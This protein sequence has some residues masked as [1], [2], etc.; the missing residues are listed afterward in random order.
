[1]TKKKENPQLAGRKTLYKPEYCKQMLDFFNIS[2]TRIEYKTFFNKKTGE[3]ETIEI[4]KA[5]SLPTFEKF[6]ANIGVHRETILNWTNEYPEFFDTYKRCKE[7]QK[8]MLIDLGMLGYYNAPFTQFVAKNIT[9]MNDK[10]QTELTGK[11]GEPL[12]VKKVYVTPEQ[13]KAVEE[14]IKKAIE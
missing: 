10:T 13:Q 2:H 11:D 6:S 7:L 1:M 3:P 4:E 8:D 9:D 12:T 5:N 14:H